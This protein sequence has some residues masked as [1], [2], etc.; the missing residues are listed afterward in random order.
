M[1]ENEYLPYKTINVFI[2]RDY[3]EIV[4]HD[5]LI[6]VKKLSK[7]KQITFSKFFKKYINILGFRDPTRA[8]LPLRINAYISAFEG[9][10]E[11]IPFTLSTWAKIKSG[12]ANKVSAWLD[13][14]GWK[15]L[16]LERDYNE[17][18]GFL[19]NWPKKLT[20]DKLV[21]KFKKDNAEIKFSRDDLI[22]MVLWISGQLPKDQ[23]G[24]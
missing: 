4:L 21:K 20:F 7:A 6:G 9:K 19:T 18:E 23:S 22:L 3:L 5:I 2:N 1:A 15:D 11:V 10:D 14:E 8:P 12:F 17:E 13:A 24:I 16:S